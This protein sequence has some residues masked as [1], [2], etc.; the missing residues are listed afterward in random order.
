MARAPPA[1]IAQPGRARAPGPNR[2]PPGS[3][4]GVG[5]TS[6]PELLAWQTR[7]AALFPAPPARCP[8]FGASVVPRF[9]PRPDCSA[10]AHVRPGAR[11]EDAKGRLP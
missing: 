9:L 10:E 5:P 8:A 2:G 4:G 11:D 7:R 1:P 6:R 3:R